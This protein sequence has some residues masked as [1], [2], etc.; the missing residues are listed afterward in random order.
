MFQY[1]GPIGPA[2]HPMF[3]L[4]DNLEKRHMLPCLVV[5]IRPVQI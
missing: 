1:G 4:K 5:K 2:Q 3:L